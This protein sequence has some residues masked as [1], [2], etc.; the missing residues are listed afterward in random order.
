MLGGGSTPAPTTAGAPFPVFLG[1]LEWRV[2]QGK[3]VDLAGEDTRT[4]GRLRVDHAPACASTEMEL[5]TPPRQVLEGEGTGWWAAGGESQPVPAR[6]EAREPR[7]KLVDAKVS[8]RGEVRCP[9]V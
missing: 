3:L 7:G 8:G 2:L 1:S 5:P 4:G 6:I 9:G